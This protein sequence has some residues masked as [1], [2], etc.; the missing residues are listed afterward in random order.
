MTLHTS[1]ARRELVF[2]YEGVFESTSRSSSVI[3]IY[4]QERSINYTADN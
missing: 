3:Y 1:S 4:M 2:T